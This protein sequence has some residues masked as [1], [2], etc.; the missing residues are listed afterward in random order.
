MATANGVASKLAGSQEI[1]RRS[2]QVVAK[3]IATSR[4][5]GV[6]AGDID[7]RVGQS[8]HFVRPK[9][10]A[11][12]RRM[13]SIFLEHKKQASTFIWSSVALILALRMIF[14]LDTLP[15]LGIIAVFALFGWNKYRKLCL[16]PN[17]SVSLVPG[18]N[19][20]RTPTAGFSSA[21]CPRCEIVLAIPES[22]RRKRI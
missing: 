3:P 19:T 20:W 21:S 9:D 13:Q 11:A 18:N 5:K 10:I 15:L 8:L 14:P 12:E 22:D 4:P 7:K 17:C 2:A 16:C 1:L 6:N